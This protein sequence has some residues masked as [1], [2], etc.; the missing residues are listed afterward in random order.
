MPQPN[1]PV[2]ARVHHQ[3]VPL[4]PAS[5]SLSICELRFDSSSFLSARSVELRFHAFQGFGP[6]LLGF[7]FVYACPNS[8]NLH[9]RPCCLIKIHINQNFIKFITRCFRIFSLRRGFY[10]LLFKI[11]PPLVLLID[12]SL[13]LQVQDLDFLSSFYMSTCLKIYSRW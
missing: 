12:S 6:F 2:L 1:W 4:T 7:I 9:L 13:M 3:W 5:V 10:F 8:G 11:F